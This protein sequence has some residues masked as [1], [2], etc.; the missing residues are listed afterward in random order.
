MSDF[1]PGP[2]ATTKGAPI[3]PSTLGNNASR[4]HVDQ[5]ATAQKIHFGM[6]LADHRRRK[7]RAV[8]AIVSNESSPT[9]HC[10]ARR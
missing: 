10:L 2:P 1:A 6:G 9:P 4:A 7:A 3:A 5:A 8:S